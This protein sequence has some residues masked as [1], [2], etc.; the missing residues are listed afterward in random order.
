MK[1]VKLLTALMA[2]A[3]LSLMGCM[4]ADGTYNHTATGAAIGTSVGAAAGALISNQTND[5]SCDDDDEECKA[6]NNSGGALV[7]AAM[8]G[9][10]GTAIGYNMEQ[11]EQ[12]LRQDLSGSGA[13]IT[14]TGD[15]LVVTLPEAITFP[16]DGTTVKSSLMG[17]LAS[18]ASNIN[19]YPGTIIQVVGNTDSSGSES[20]NQTLS[21]RRAQSVANILVADGVAPSRVQTVGMGENAPI[22]SNSTEAGRAQNRRVDINIIP[23]Q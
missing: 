10:V 11:Q 13:V 16:V 1:N 5:S 8:G 20:Y 23:V 12:D 15:K 7:G 18:L 22:A 4:D 2:T 9:M 3:S 21:E 6:N 14:N 17:P 19:D